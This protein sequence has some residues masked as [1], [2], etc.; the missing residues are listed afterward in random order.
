[1]SLIAELKR[2]NVLRVAAGYAVVS[3]LV[4]Q[5]STTI[6]PLFEAPPWIARA[7]VIVLAV[8]ALPVLALSW[9]YAW[10]PQ[11]LKTQDEADAAGLT[12]RVSGTR[13]N[14][15]IAL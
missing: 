9:I 12:P 1:M 4:V 2:S 11:G 14:L 6:L 5:V 15:A 7:L 10:T 13:L 3:W 8:G